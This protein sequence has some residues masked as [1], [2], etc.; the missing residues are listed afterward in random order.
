MTALGCGGL[1]FEPW[2]DERA[3]AVLRDLDVSDQLEAALFRG[4]NAEP[5]ALFADWRA[6]NAYRATSLVVLDARRKPFALLGIMGTGAQGVAQAALLARGHRR[7]RR[8]L[9]RLAVSLRRE[10]AGYAAGHGFSRIEC[11]AWSAHPTASRLL[12][13]LGFV[14]EC[15]MPGFSG[16]AIVFRQFAWTAPPDPE[17][18][19]AT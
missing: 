17:P 6:A 14:A 12:D 10:I 7:W 3:F 16:G 1:I 11:R 19:T 5:L 13:A 2:S 9:A 8:H 15:D 4:D 18:E